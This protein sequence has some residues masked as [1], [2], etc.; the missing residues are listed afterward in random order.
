[1]TNVDEVADVVEAG[2]L[3][4]FVIGPIGNRLAPAGS[5]ERLIYEDAVQVLEEAI[6]PACKAVGLDPVRADGLARAGEITEQVFRRLRDDDVVIADLSGANA[7]VMYELGLRHTKSKLTVQLGEYG[8]LPFDVNVIRT[9]QF[10]RS[11]HGLVQARNELIDLLRAGLAGQY[12]PVGATRVWNEDAPGNADEPQELA[13]PAEPER[14][15]EEPAGFLDRVAEGEVKMEDLNELTDRIASRFRQMGKL[16]E[17]ASAKNEA[18]D[19]QGRGVRGR[20]AVA[21]Q[22]AH[23][24][25]E[26]AEGI[27][28]DVEQY[29]AA[30]SSVSD[31]TLAL[32]ERVEEDPSELGEVM[33]W[34]LSVRRLA[35]A[36]RDSMASLGGMLDTMEENAK[37]ARVL[38]EPTRRI[39][40][41]LRRQAQEVGVMDEWDRRLQA[42]GVPVPPENW[43]PES[44]K[45]EAAAIDDDVEAAIAPTE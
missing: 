9:V 29:T 3:T 37:L 11:A 25:G 41:A 12:D 31:G 42:L 28:A 13:V 44:V 32:I 5:D 19:A 10:S 14:E 6:V 8:R 27:E 4:C 24:L 26:I 1:V 43:E 40:T 36:A 39:T 23:S 18:S 7:N 35:A 15:A 17:Q 20:L 30:L 34:A 21:V 38:R 2:A 16:A 33:D 22:Y 45:L